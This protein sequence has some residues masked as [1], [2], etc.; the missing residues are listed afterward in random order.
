VDPRA[1]AVTPRR[2]YRGPLGH[3][4]LGVPLLGNAMEVP[5]GREKGVKYLLLEFGGWDCETER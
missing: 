3:A 5:P 1:S 4:K 2:W